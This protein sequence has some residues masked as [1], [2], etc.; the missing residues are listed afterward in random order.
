M[1]QFIEHAKRADEE[2]HCSDDGGSYSRGGLRR[3]PD[4]VLNELSAL[5]THQVL[6]LIH[7][8]ALRSRTSTEEAGN[9]DDDDQQRRKRKCRIV[10]Q[11]RGQT[12]GLIILPFLN[13]LGCQI[14]N[15]AGCHKINI[16]KK[17]LSLN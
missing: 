3:A 11:C 7:D 5:H 16:P 8:E 2:G 4:H 1:L 9:R 17:R 6:H 13:G 12:R 15:A 10:S 14:K